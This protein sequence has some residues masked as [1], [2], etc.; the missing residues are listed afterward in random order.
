[1]SGL[2]PD[3]EHEVHALQELLE[4]CRRSEFFTFTIGCSPL[5]HLHDSLV[6]DIPPSSIA[7]VLQEFQ[8]AITAL[9]SGKCPV[10]EEVVKNANASLVVAKKLAFTPDSSK[11]LFEMIEGTINYACQRGAQLSH[12]GRVVCVL[13]EDYKKRHAEQYQVDDIVDLLALLA[14][15]MEGETTS[16]PGNHLPGFHTQLEIAILFNSA[17]FMEEWAQRKHNLSRYLYER[18]YTIRL[19]KAL[20]EIFLEE[21]PRTAEQEPPSGGLSVPGIIRKVRSI[22]TLFRNSERQ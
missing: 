19:H 1:M 13:L 3:R 20:E 9:N 4:S 22:R 16:F 18:G 6:I 15:V 12:F 10:Y 7:L 2:P 17:R 14:V 5:P 21:I 8:A 11:Q